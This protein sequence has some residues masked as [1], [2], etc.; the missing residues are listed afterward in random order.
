MKRTDLSGD[1]VVVTEF[2]DSPTV[3]PKITVARLDCTPLLY[4]PHLQSAIEALVAERS[5]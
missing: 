4:K 3:R 5:Q 1:G 2:P